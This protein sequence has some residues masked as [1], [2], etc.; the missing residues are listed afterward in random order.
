MI[1][2]GYKYRK[3]ILN[4]GG[5]NKYKSNIEVLNDLTKNRK[6][7][8]E[9]DK[10]CKSCMTAIKHEESAIESMKTS[11]NNKLEMVDDNIFSSVC[12]LVTDVYTTPCPCVETIEEVQDKGNTGLCSPKNKPMVLEYVKEIVDK[13]EEENNKIV[14]P[15]ELSDTDDTVLSKVATIMKN[16]CN[17]EDCVLASVVEDSMKGNNSVAKKLG[18]E[19][20]ILDECS[21]P[22]KPNGPRMTTE[23]LSNDNI[24]QVL[25][26]IEKEFEEF[27]YFRTTM[28]D[29]ESGGDTYLS[30]PKDKSL[31]NCNNI[32]QKYLNNNKKTCFGCVIN[33]DKTENCKMGKCGTHWVSIFIDC[34][35]TSDV[36]YSIEYFDSVGDPPSKDITIWMENIKEKL[37]NYRTE[38]D[39]TSRGGVITEVNTISHQTGNNECGVY[40]CYFIRARVEGIPFSRFLNR[41]LPDHFMIEYRKNLFS[42][43]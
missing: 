17:T 26:D 14:K 23:W 20:S 1:I 31:S 41:R 15:K 13:Y 24:D 37:D 40:G 42:S 19:T 16:K 7:I 33:T 38:I 6:S 30:I 10:D 34:R 29:F 3:N 27:F 36:P 25:D 18:I 9:I 11:D 21:S 12:S 39:S 22:L 32:I 35:R 4:K 8:C 43:K 28:T 5:S 2:G